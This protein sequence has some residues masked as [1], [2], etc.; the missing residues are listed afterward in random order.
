MT[1]QTEKL[2]DRPQYWMMIH[3]FYS[4]LV[5]TS[6]FESQSAPHVVGGPVTSCVTIK[7]SQRPVTSNVLGSEIESSNSGRSVTTSANSGSGSKSKSVHTGKQTAFSGILPLSDNITEDRKSTKAKRRP[8]QKL[9]ITPSVSSIIPL[10]S[11]VDVD[12]S[13]VVSLISNAFISNVVILEHRW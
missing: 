11:L 1:G 4:T 8:K 5:A 2:R 10:V 3:T 13:D 7:D 9:S 12:N 6:G